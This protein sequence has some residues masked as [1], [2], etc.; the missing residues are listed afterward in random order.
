MYFSFS[1]EI[2]FLHKLFQPFFQTQLWMFLMPWLL[3]AVET[4]TD[5]ILV[6]QPFIKFHQQELPHPLSL[7]WQI[8]MVWAFDSNGDFYLAE[9]SAG[10]INKYDSS[11]TLII[12]IPVGGIASGLIKDFDSDAMIFT[13]VVNNSV[14][15]LNT[16]GTITE[17]II[18]APLNAPVGLAFDS[19]GN[20]FVANFTGN[21][22]YK[23]DG[24]L[25]YVA[26][27]PDGGATGGNAAVGFIVYAGGNLY[28]TNFGG[29]QIYKVNPLAVDDFSLYAGDLQGGDDGPITAANFDYPNGIIYNASENAFYV[30]EYSANG[31]IRKISDAVLGVTNNIENATI[32][33]G[34]NPT[35]DILNISGTLN[36]TSNEMKLMV[37]NNL[38]QLLIEKSIP[39]KDETINH[40]ISV[41][42]LAKGLYHIKLQASTGT[43]LSESFIKN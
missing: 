30:S 11:G 6:V 1:S 23:L 28:A 27:V 24:T 19:T 17:L 26:T 21:Q 3:I 10:T 43:I 32:Y 8:Q 42:Q 37:Y 4:Y 12:A 9:Y 33:I 31:N 25:E 15:K 20:L 29:H 13:N 22:I 2:V 35:S 7:D 18:G 38:G 40:Q 39:V 16:D 14:N 41:G 5:L 34:P 36:F